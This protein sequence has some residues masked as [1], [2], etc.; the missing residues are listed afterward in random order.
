M[1]AVTYHNK[2]LSPYKVRGV[3]SMLAC[4]ERMAYPVPTKDILQPAKTATMC[5]APCA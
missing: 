4:V 3:F 5:M 1:L 2:D